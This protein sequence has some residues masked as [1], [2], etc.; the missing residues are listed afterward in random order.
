MKKTFQIKL[1]AQFTF[2][3]SLYALTDAQQRGGD[4]AKQLIIDLFLDEQGIEQFEVTEHNS[5]S[6]LHAIAAVV[7]AENEYMMAHSDEFKLE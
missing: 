6:L 2:D 1:N 3:F 7:R 5:H 4:E